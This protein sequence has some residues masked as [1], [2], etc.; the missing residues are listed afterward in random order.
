MSWKTVS[1]PQSDNRVA[2]RHE[3][4]VIHGITG[5][6][7]RSGQAEPE[8]LRAFETWRMGAPILG[9]HIGFDMKF[10]RAAFARNKINGSIEDH[11]DLAPL[12]QMLLNDRSNNLED[13][14]TRL[15]IKIQSRH[16]AAADAWM[17]ALL[18]AHLSELAFK[19]GVKRLQVACAR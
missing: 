4:I 12:A 14:L 16:N 8:V 5:S 3:N 17:T 9:W 7:Q 13:Y 11:C 1:K 6:Q 19:Q 2:S 15:G 10:L 18:A